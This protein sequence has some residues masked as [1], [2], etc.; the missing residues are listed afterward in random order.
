MHPDLRKYS[1]I[2][3]V[4]T[5]VVIKMVLSVVI[6]PSPAWAGDKNLVDS[7]IY[8]WEEREGVFREQQ[9]IMTV[10]AYDWTHFTVSG[11]H[12]LAVANAFTGQTTLTDSAL[13]FFRDDTF[14]QFQTMEVQ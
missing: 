4:K 8:L 7:V 5:K 1:Y 3:P 11:F 6:V 13:Y 9:R 10:G 12:F 14:V 2:E